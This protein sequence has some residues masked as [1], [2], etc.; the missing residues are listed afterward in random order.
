[1]SLEFGPIKYAQDTIISQEPAKEK[2]DNDDPFYIVQ[3]VALPA[4]AKDIVF[5]F[6]IEY[7]SFKDFGPY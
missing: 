4:K 3:F 1:M 2:R 7:T 5:R 6:I